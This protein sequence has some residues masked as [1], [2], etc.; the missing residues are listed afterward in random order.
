MQAPHSTSDPCQVS[1]REFLRRLSVTCG[2]VAI[3]GCGG[4][5]SESA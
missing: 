2:S 4:G 5:A 3:A 1:R